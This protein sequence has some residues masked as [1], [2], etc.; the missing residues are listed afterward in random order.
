MTISWLV[1][2]Y[3]T[4]SV[5]LNSVETKKILNIKYIPSQEIPKIGEIFKRQNQ[6]HGVPAKNFNEIQELFFQMFCGEFKC[7]L[8]DI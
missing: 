4:K 6:D 3:N 2:L 8:K 7:C 1:F 5:H